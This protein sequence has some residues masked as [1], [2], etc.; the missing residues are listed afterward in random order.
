[1]GI[2]DV[3]CHTLAQYLPSDPEKLK[4]I[5]LDIEGGEVEVLNALF[6]DGGL[7]R[8]IILMELHIPPATRSWIEELANRIG[9]NIEFYQFGPVTAH[10]QLTSPD[11]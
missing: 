6:K 9:Y 10:C 5:K 8:T 11:L 2:I 1:L 4:L 3:S 7:K